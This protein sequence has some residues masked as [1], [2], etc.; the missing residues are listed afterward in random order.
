MFRCESCHCLALDKQLHRC[1]PKF[2]ARFEDDG[3]DGDTWAEV[4]AHD[5]ESAAEEFAAESDR[6]GD[7]MVLRGGEHNV[8]VRDRDGEITTWVVTAE[9]TPVYT[10]HEA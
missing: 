10:A 3:G 2:E 9:A 8:L 1:P 7:Y 4:Y 6:G 5:P